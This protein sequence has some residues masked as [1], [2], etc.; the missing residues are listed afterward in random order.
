MHHRCGAGAA[1]H[2][3]WGVCTGLC[4]GDAKWARH[5]PGRARRRD[6]R[7][8]AAGHDVVLV[9]Q[10]A[11]SRAHRRAAANLPAARRADLRFVSTRSLPPTQGGDAW[12]PTSSGD[13]HHRAECVG[14]GGE[15]QPLRR[16]APARLGRSG[17]SAQGSRRHRPDARLGGQSCDSGGS[18]SSGL[19]RGW[20]A[21]REVATAQRPTAAPPPLVRWMARPVGQAVDQRALGVD[22]GWQYRRVL[23][24]R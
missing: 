10:R 23:Q 22:D 11:G 6:H 12:G 14:R 21:P 7:A 16:W 3:M 19:A 8:A 1:C 9:D 20:S 17:A 24:G 18:A 13:P 2:S 4:L 5:R 15:A